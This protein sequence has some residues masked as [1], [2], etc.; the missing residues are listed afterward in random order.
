MEIV[1]VINKKL[2][3]REMREVKGLLAQLRKKCLDNGIDAESHVYAGYASEE[4]LI[5]AKDYKASLISLG[6]KSEK[7][8]L[9]R[10]S[11]FELSFLL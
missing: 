8:L 2:T 10:I 9:K 3:I 7:N 4:I 6:A 1:K 11:S 5:A